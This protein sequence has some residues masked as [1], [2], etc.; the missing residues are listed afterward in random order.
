MP[1]L[2]LS[3]LQANVLMPVAVHQP[4]YDVDIL[5]AR[6]AFRCNTCYDALKKPWCMLSCPCHLNTLHT[7]GFS[8][9]SSVSASAVR[10]TSRCCSSANKL[11]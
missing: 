8:S 3:T 7:W 1:H 5:Q 2:L 6:G 11:M 9:P 4:A 10:Y